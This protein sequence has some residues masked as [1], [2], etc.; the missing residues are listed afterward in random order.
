M[1]NPLSRDTA[2]LRAWVLL[3][4]GNKLDLVDPNPSA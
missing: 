3:C 4:R 1:N 2:S